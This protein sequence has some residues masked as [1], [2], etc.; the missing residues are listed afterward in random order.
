MPR[1]GSTAI[2]KYLY[3]YYNGELIHVRHAS[4]K[5]ACLKVYEKYN[6]K[7]NEIYKVIG[8]RNPFDSTVSRYHKTKD[9]YGASDYYKSFSNQAIRDFARQCHVEQWTF[10]K[11][12]QKLG[13]INDKNTTGKDYLSSLRR[14]VY[15]P[16]FLQEIISGSF[17]KLIYF[18][19]INKDFNKL[20]KHLTGCD[21]NIKIDLINVTPKKN[22]F[23]NYKKYYDKETKNFIKKVFLKFMKYTHYEFNN[24][25]FI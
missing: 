13:T 25:K 24:K 11:W 6:Y 4:L 21:K 15:N 16:I 20:I 19:N 22:S 10:K 23:E 14:G 7:P 1:T 8:V 18:E 12:L 9:L 3:N 17:D 2:S 5:D